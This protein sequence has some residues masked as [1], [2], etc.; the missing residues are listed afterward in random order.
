VTRA[1]EAS[2]RLCGGPIR[3]A[4]APGRWLAIQP[5]PVPGGAWAVHRDIG[6]CL[7]ARPLTADRPSLEGAERPAMPHTCNPEREEET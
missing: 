3:W 7:R 4:A 6:G 5:N 2:C 1:D